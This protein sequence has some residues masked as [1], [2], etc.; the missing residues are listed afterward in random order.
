MSE[1]QS[2]PVNEKMS[3]KMIKARSMNEKY[4]KASQFS[5]QE[6][7][8]KLEESPQTLGERT[9]YLINMIKHAHNHR[10]AGISG[11]G[12]DAC[13]YL[14]YLP[15]MALRL[16][17]RV[18]IIWPFAQ[19]REILIK[20]WIVIRKLV[21]RF[22]CGELTSKDSRS[23][24]DKALALAVFQ[25]NKHN[26]DIL[27]GRG[28]DPNGKL[29]AGTPILLFAVCA[30][31]HDIARLLLEAGA[32]T[33]VRDPASKAPAIWFAVHNND[34]S[35]ISLLLKHRAVP[36]ECGITRITALMEAVAVENIEIVQ[37]LLDAGA[38]P[39]KKDVC[40]SNAIYLAKN[41]K[42]EEIVKLIT[43]YG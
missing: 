26:V 17:I 22:R 5:D 37:M 6:T 24:I 12:Y 41:K 39:L 21:V 29:L 23:S 2:I 20:K 4:S 32:S 9:R 34:I 42:L 10:P 3:I 1:N 25:G 11:V 15:Q 19:S 31:Q 35:M 36:D 8:L 28:A 30:N 43:N 14:V 16:Y 38:D 18:F 33:N 7:I 40:G 27:L 13:L